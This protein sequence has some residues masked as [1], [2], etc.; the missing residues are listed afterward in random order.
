MNPVLAVAT[1]VLFITTVLFGLMALAPSS[2]PIKTESVQRAADTNTEVDIEDVSARFMRNLLTYKYQT[3]DNDFEQ[4]LQDA[5]QEFTTR[6]LDALE[7]ISV[8]DFKSEIKRTRGSS[9]ADVQ[10]VDIDS[11]DSGTATVV[12]VYTRTI[13][14]NQR[15]RP[16]RVLEV[17][18]LT[19][20]ETDDGWKV[21]NA[22]SPASAT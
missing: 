11:R 16:G 3:V 21:D 5:T 7:G 18:E 4:A 10:S 1:V 13:D 14:S 8:D 15:D 22:A 17:I 9:S 19:L 20:R 12:V 6:P 2:A